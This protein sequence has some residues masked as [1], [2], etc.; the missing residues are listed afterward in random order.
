MRPLLIHGIGAHYG[1]LA[2]NIIRLLGPEAEWL[3]VREKTFSDGER[4]HKLDTNPEGRDVIIVAG[5]VNDQLTLDLYDLGYAAVENGACSLTMIIPYFGYSTME[6]EV[7]EKRTEEP[8]ASFQRGEAVKAATRASLLSA[9]P[10][11][12]EGNR[13][14]LLDLHSEGIPH[15]FGKEMRKQHIYTED[16]VIA[17]CRRIIKASGHDRWTL[18]GTDTGRAKWIES[19][20]QI[21]KLPVALCVKDHDPITDK[22]S[23]K[24]SIGD[25]DKRGVILFDDMIRTGGS[26]NDAA[27]AYK[28]KGA[29]EIHGICT[30]GVFPGNSGDKLLASGRYASLSCTNSHP[31][32]KAFGRLKIEPLFANALR[33]GLLAR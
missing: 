26:F 31:N 16:L 20:S 8:T 5:S 21:L 18:G 11:A 4:Y 17:E 23:L 7:P 25:V 3:R 30:H 33:R 13:V 29:R 28:A 32:S 19:L 9:I 2:Q 10:K 24:A 6:R 14:I 1:E 12:P 27:D 22:T 15:Y